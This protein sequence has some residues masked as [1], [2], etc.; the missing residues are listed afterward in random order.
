MP[1][2]EFTLPSF[3]KINLHLRVLG[4]RDDGYHEICTVFQ[5]ISL[6]DELSFAPSK[7]LR[8]TCSHAGI[9][10]AGDNL[11]VAAAELLRTRYSINKGARI[12]LEKRIP[13]PG[14]L[15][16][17][18]SNAAISL[19]GLS[20]LWKI[21]V[22]K[23]ELFRLAAELGSDVP[24]FLLGGTALGTGRGEVLEKLADIDEPSLLIVTPDISVSTRNAFNGLRRGSLTN[25]DSNHI[26]QN[27]RFEVGA[28]D[29]RNS[30]LIN[31][32]EESVFAIHPVIKRVKQTLL[33]LGAIQAAMSGSGA[34]IF[35]VFDNKETRQATLK[36]LESE[37]SWRKFAVAAISRSEY[38][39]ALEIAY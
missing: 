35:A 36:A 9:P 31:D 19:I 21:E 14:G 22:E 32:F 24:F 2:S 7:D 34:S 37:S 20:R 6:C 30:V 10:T 27:C 13:S 8:L 39:K 25:E 5:T 3:A 26:L 33:D 18:S 29:M 16:G 28:L 17:G 23:N 38:R 12:H 4:K 11:I 1:D 15:G